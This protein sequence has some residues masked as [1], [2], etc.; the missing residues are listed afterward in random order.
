L[1]EEKSK[2]NAGLA[3]ENGFGLVKFYTLPVARKRRSN[4]MHLQK[5][6]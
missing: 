2:T 4:T 3:Q 1:D 6:V 5:R